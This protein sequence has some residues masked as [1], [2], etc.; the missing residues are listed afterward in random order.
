M[1]SSKDLWSD[2][3]LAAMGVTREEYDRKMEEFYKEKKAHK[4]EYNSMLK[5]HI[6]ENDTE[7][8]CVGADD[9]DDIAVPS[10]NYF[11]AS[12]IG[13]LSTCKLDVHQQ[14]FEDL[15]KI[16]L[17][18]E[19]ETKVIQLYEN[20]SKFLLKV[21]AVFANLQEA[22]FYC[23]RMHKRNKNMDYAVGDCNKWMQLPINVKREDIKYEDP[24]L[25]DL[26]TGYHKMQDAT[27]EVEKMFQEKRHSKA[28]KEGEAA[29]NA[30][31]GGQSSSS[32]KPPPE[33][34]QLSL[35][36]DMAESPPVIPT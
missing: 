27:I 7:Y 33:Y 31:E 12:T 16:G 5:K 36:K 18:P 24:F 23:K 32:S 13:P 15:K 28:L 10:Q 30:I 34:D 26:F 29:R 21:R 14:M 9:I 20:Y 8:P 4:E 11:V 17:T 22:D 35:F 6:E 25:N 1:P 19:Q 2:E 3:Q